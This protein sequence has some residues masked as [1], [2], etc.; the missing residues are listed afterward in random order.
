M[1][2]SN[3]FFIDFFIKK[4]FYEIKKKENSNFLDLGCGTRPYRKYYDSKFEKV[5]AGDF[6]KRIED[7]DL[8]LDAQ[9]L[10]FEPNNF[11]TILFTEV[12]EHIPDPTKAISEIS[13]CLKTNGE[14]ILT[15]PFHH[16]MHEVPYDFTRWTE[17]G[18]KKILNDHNLK[19][20]KMMRRGNIF[21]L[22]L[23]L[24]FEIFF[25]PFEAF[26]RIPIIGL[27]FYPLKYIYM[28]VYELIFYI[29]FNI[30]KNSSNLN[31]N[32]EIGTKLNGFRTIGRW[33]LGYCMICKKV[34]VNEG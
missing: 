29:H 22:L 32:N 20:V 13:R 24:I 5:I 26:V 14:L 10:P 27:L 21:S 2:S 12:L 8:I 3:N 33:T 15:F 31:F 11:D 7:V 34:E 16:P 18:I 30:I 28:K 25:Y 1:K 4:Y 19:I 23:V 17:F 9:D 6:E